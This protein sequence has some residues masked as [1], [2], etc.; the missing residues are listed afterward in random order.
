MLLGTSEMPHRINRC[1]ICGQHRRTTVSSGGDCGCVFNLFTANR[2]PKS[3]SCNMSDAFPL[4]TS[5]SYVDATAPIVRYPP[6]YFGFGAAGFRHVSTVLD[7]LA[8]AASPV[9]AV[10]PS[11]NTSPQLDGQ[12]KSGRR[13]APTTRRRGPLA[14]YSAMK[15]SRGYSIW[16]AVINNIPSPSKERI[17]ATYLGC[18]DGINVSDWST[19]RKHQFSAFHASH[20]EDEDL[21][22]VPIGLCPACP[23]DLCCK[24]EGQR[25]DIYGQKGRHFDTCSAYRALCE[26]TNTRPEPILTNRAAV[27]ALLKERDRLRIAL[28]FKTPKNAPPT[29]PIT[30]L[31]L[32][33]PVAHASPSDGVCDPNHIEQQYLPIGMASVPSLA[34]SPSS[35][36]VSSRILTPTEQSGLQNSWSLPLMHNPSP[37]LIDGTTRGDSHGARNLDVSFPAYFPPNHAWI[38][39]WKNAPNLATPMGPDIVLSADELGVNPNPL[40]AIFAPGDKQMT[41]HDVLANLGTD[42]SEVLNSHAGIFQEKDEQVK[43]G[44]GPFLPLGEGTLE[45]LPHG[46]FPAHAAQQRV[47]DLPPELYELISATLEQRN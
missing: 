35:S 2:P 36:K 39:E 46:S 37:A 7:D 12:P 4:S 25:V 31:P 18:C 44:G 32:L 13:T 9:R 5:G 22:Y 17:T 23:E 41:D 42:I 16:R 38:S 20:L 33:T 40:T 15:D 24:D 8:L 47:W 6:G 11:A 30:P 28:R 43:G 27:K 21:Q 29:F 19:L 1:M 34:L 14:P 10:L 3:I 26:R 45:L